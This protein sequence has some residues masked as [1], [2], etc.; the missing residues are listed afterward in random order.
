MIALALLAAHMIGDYITQTGWMAANK[1]NNWRARAIHVSVYTA[2]FIPVALLT[3][4]TWSMVLLFVALVWATHFI[5][6]CRRWASGDQ[7]PPK[8]ILVDQSIHIATLAILGI[9]FRL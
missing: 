5:T 8:P 4:L 7:W 2:G 9:A 3:K 1:L 6:D